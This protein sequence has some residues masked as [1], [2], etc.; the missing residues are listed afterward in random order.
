MGSQRVGHDRVTFTFT[1]N[2]GKQ[3][4]GMQDKPRAVLVN[5]VLLK[6]S[7]SH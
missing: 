1:S 3:D 5:K 4:I 7:Q 6:Y 2:Q